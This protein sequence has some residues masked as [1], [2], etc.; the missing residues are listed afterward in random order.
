[1]ETTIADYALFIENVMQGRG[2]TKQTKRSMLTQ[3]IA[4]HS[5]HQFPT[6][7]EETTTENEAINLSYGLGWG[8][9]TSKYGRAFFKEGHDDGWNHYNINFIEKGISIIMMTNSSNGEKIFKDVLEKVIGD[10]FTPWQWERYIPKYV[11]GER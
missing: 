3:Q 8:L 7:T 11:N 2:L 4:I 1:L 10:T 5:K 6:I 9:L